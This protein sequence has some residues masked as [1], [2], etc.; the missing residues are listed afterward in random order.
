MKTVFLSFWG[1]LNIMSFCLFL[2][3]DSVF[4]GRIV[5]NILNQNKYSRQFNSLINDDIFLDETQC[6]ISNKNK[7][8][9]CDKDIEL[10]L[11]GNN[12]IKNKKVISISPGGIKGFYELGVL[13][14]IKENYDM[15]NYIFSG[16]SSGAWNAL[17][18]TYKNDTKKFVYNLFDYKITQFK[19]INDFEY[20]LK[21]NLLSNYNS[22]DF[23]L[24]RLF[25][26][27]TTLKN[28]RPKTNIFSDFTN[29]EDAINCCIASAHIP[30]ITGGLTNRYHNMYTFDGGFSNYPYVNFT[31]NVL[32]ITPSMWKNKNN[33]NNNRNKRAFV[34]SISNVYSSLNIIYNLIKNTKTANLMELYDDGYQDAKENKHL[35]DEIFIETDTDMVST[36]TDGVQDNDNDN[37]N[38]NNNIDV[39]DNDSF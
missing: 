27:V 15:E 14:F 13:S 10:F 8:I 9:Y 20:V 25:I 33:R 32:H 23:D 22:D 35:L 39:L 12:F 31:E 1:L 30:L 36:I 18:M 26:G 21:Y 29:L 28:F 4:S 11:E 5:G 6:I 24:P 37:D 17:F 7:L 16:A 2:H 19:N 38:D 3:C 34:K